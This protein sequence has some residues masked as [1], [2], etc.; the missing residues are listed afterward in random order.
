MT[1]G[2]LTRATAWRLIPQVWTSQEEGGFPRYNAVPARA[3]GLRSPAGAYCDGRET[4]IGHEPVS[5]WE[6]PLMDG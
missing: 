1:S 5:S 6:Y 3:A 2:A 4:H